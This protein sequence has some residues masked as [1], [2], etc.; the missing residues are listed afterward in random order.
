MGLATLPGCSESSETISWGG[1]HTLCSLA[2]LPHPPAWSDGGGGGS[3]GQVALA[4][5]AQVG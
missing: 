5:V 3:R 1:G 2:V 4:A